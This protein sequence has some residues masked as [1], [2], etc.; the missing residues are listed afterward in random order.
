DEFNGGR[1]SGAAIQRFTKYAYAHW[2][3]RFLLLVGDGTLDPNGTQV[4]SGKDGIP[5]LPTP[6][7]VGAADGLEIVPS[8]NRYGFITGNEDPISSPDTNRVVPELMV[9]RLLVNSV[10]EAAT[11]VAKIVGYENVQPGDAWRKGVLLT[12]DDA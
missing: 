9:G 8:D 3:S 1:H 2:N 11:A 4:G 5:G 12:A 6:A 10:A 7:P